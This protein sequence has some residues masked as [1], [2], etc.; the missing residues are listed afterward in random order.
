MTKIENSKT[1]KTELELPRRQFV[2]AAFLT[3]I[4]LFSG[5]EIRAAS[6]EE[7]AESVLLPTPGDALV[8]I[9][10]FLFGVES[11]ILRPYYGVIGGI[12]GELGF[13]YSKLKT[14]AREFQE[15]V[16]EL[17]SDADLSRFRNTAEIGKATAVYISQLSEINNA[18]FVKDHSNF[19]KLNSNDLEKLASDLRQQSDSITLSPA[20]VEKLR[21][22]LKMIASLG[23]I[24][25]SLNDASKALTN[26]S[27]A[28]RGE[29]GVISKLLRDA[30]RFL[31]SAVIIESPPSANALA[32]VIKRLE[33]KS[34][35]TSAAELR[36][37]AAKKTAEASNNLEKLN[38]YQ[39]PDFL[40]KQLPPDF[41]ASDMK[42][43][44]EIP[45]TVLV[46]MLNG[47]VAWIKRGDTAPLQ[48]NNRTGGE[49]RFI[50]ANLV[51][52]PAGLFSIWGKIWDILAT[53]LPQA[54]TRR[55]GELFVEKI[56]ASIYS[57]EKQTQIFYNLLPRLSDPNEVNLYTNKSV[58]QDVAERIAQ[59]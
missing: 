4:G 47:V 49:V 46:D 9:M 35:P 44:A 19:I 59:L 16:P 25:T 52:A 3:G 22:M 39:V 5:A 36:E 6:N 54:T 48:T 1:C 31:F 14:L 40:R 8:D 53:I 7:E 37:L 26:A 56:T 18:G 58:R 17:K 41:N 45:I 27:N 2:S 24:T 10:E 15:L 33:E 12:S 57:V 28:I 11:G 29:V 38:N 55:A 34:E 43:D 20:A 23:K 13:Q 30:A 51:T 32:A 50:S 21:E 42:N